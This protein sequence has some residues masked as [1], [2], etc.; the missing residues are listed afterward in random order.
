[1]KKSKF[2]EIALVCEMKKIAHLYGKSPSTILLAAKK[3]MKD[4]TFEDLD[5]YKDKSTGDLRQMLSEA[6]DEVQKDGGAHVVSFCGSLQDFLSGKVKA[7]SGLDGL[8]DPL[9][10]L[11]AKVGG[12]SVSPPIPVKGNMS[13]EDFIKMMMEKFGSQSPSPEGDDGKN[14]G[15]G[16]GSN[17][18]P[19]KPKGPNPPQKPIDS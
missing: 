2:I 7:V 13:S 5:E 14:D 6:A 10:E 12:V 3:V 19:K 8:P 9:K 15:G 17:K 16:E 1:M 4:M 18:S 11:L